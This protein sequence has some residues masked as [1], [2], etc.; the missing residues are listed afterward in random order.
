[1]PAIKCSTA[2]FA[3]LALKYA[4]LTDRSYPRFIPKLS[5]QD[6]EAALIAI[7]LGDDFQRLAMFLAPISAARDL[8]F[9]NKLRTGS[10]ATQPIVVLLDEAWSLQRKREHTRLAKFATLVMLAGSRK[11]TNRAGY[12]RTAHL[13]AVRSEELLRCAISGVKRLQRQLGKQELQETKMEGTSATKHADGQSAILCK[14]IRVGVEIRV[15]G[16]VEAHYF[17]LTCGTE[18]AVF[19]PHN[20]LVFFESILPYFLTNRIASWSEI[21]TDESTKFASGDTRQ[22]RT[23]LEKFLGKLGTPPN[24]EPWIGSVRKVGYSWNKS[25]KLT[26]TRECRNLFRSARLQYTD[27]QD[28]Q[29]GRNLDD[30]DGE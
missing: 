25:V 19:V 4:G 20:L 5:P 3:H 14:A 8:E 29:A 18:K 16:G 27:R 12:E 6:A 21:N 7:E 1:V 2:I 9:V 23:A 10:E 11:I 17:F 26:G 24:G 30:D 13:V 28:F 15:E 22:S